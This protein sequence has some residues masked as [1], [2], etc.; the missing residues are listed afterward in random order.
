[1]ERFLARVLGYTDSSPCSI[2]DMLYILGHLFPHFQS[3][4]PHLFNE[5]TVHINNYELQ[6]QRQFL[7]QL[8]QGNR[9][10]WKNRIGAVNI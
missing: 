6:V 10:C 8:C 2:I 9:K 5:R 3:Q 1:M 7:N 4:F